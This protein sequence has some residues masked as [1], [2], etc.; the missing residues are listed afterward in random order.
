[1]PAA[2]NAQ[3]FSG[4]WAKELKNDVPA[5]KNAEQKR[6]E[7]DILGLQAA[8]R[9][10][11]KAKDKA[12]LEKYY[13]PDFTMTHGS[14]AIHNKQVRVDFITAGSGG[15]EAMTPESQTIRIITNNAAVSIAI[16]SGNLGGKLT[17]I[18]Y[19]IVYAKGD[20][21]EGYKGWREAAAQVTIIP[22]KNPAAPATPT[23]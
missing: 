8:V 21:S 23:R 3:Q 6:A 17:Y 10:A 14:G 9:A 2:G 4:D 5:P 22:A 19:M 1:M 13:T 20:P 11:T 7:E 12:A 16:N 18:R 15:Y